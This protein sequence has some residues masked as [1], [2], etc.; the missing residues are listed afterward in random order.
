MSAQ[1]KAMPLFFID[2]QQEWPEGAK[3]VG[4]LV[5]WADHGKY[6]NY[7]PVA[8]A[9][10]PLHDGTIVVQAGN[11]GLIISFLDS[12][13]EVG[14][15]RE[16]SAF[17]GKLE[18]ERTKPKQY[19]VAIDAI[20]HRLLIMRHNSDAGMYDNGVHPF[21][22]LAWLAKAH[23]KEAM[24]LT[25]ALKQVLAKTTDLECAGRELPGTDAFQITEDL[26]STL[27]QGLKGKVEAKAN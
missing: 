21:S 24:V 3:L 2:N 13:N 6:P 23:P 17:N 4:D 19:R 11:R 10:S 25:H 15:R 22:L 27:E 9:R 26:I 18:D 7:V 14:I 16:M 1:P 20:I 5:L 12:K 8:T